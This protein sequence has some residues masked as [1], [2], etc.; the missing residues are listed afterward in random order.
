MV[1]KSGKKSRITLY[2]QLQRYAY[3]SY[4]VLNE[5]DNLQISGFKTNREAVLGE[6]RVALTSE[7]FRIY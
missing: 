6:H 7:S 5:F 2:Q 4:N 3:K 1:L